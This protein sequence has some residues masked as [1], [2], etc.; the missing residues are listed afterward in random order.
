GLFLRLGFLSHAR[1]SLTLDPRRIPQRGSV[2][3]HWQDYLCEGT[4]AILIEQ[5]HTAAH[6]L[7]RG[8]AEKQS[9]A[10]A[11]LALGGDEGGSQLLGDVQRYTRAMVPDA[12]PQALLVPFQADLD[13]VRTGVGGIV[14]QVEYRLPQLGTVLD[15]R[16]LALRQRPQSATDLRAHQLPA[17]QQS[18]QPAVGGL[19]AVRLAAIELGTAH[20]LLQAGLALAHLLLQ[21]L[22][23]FLNLR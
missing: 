10:E 6:P 19:H 1:S 22:Q 4:P 9:E 17:L 15:Q 5:F 7:H 3:F 14:Q 12:Q 23:V 21:Q 16:H 20:H 11:L 2:M 13:V 18:M 8:L